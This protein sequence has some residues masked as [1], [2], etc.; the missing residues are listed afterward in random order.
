MR[1][2]KHTNGEADPGSS[3]PPTPLRH[4]GAPPPPPRNL[5][6]PFQAACSCDRCG[7]EGCAGLGRLSSSAPWSPAGT[8]SWLGSASSPAHPASLS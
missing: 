8:T 7:H 3:A 1:V 2:R 5:R 6:A 4:M